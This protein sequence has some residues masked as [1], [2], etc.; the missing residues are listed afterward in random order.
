VSGA[1][2]GGIGNSGGPITQ[3]SPSD[4][5]I[6]PGL[7][8]SHTISKI[9]WNCFARAKRGQF[10]PSG[11]S[12][13]VAASRRFVY[14]SG[15]RSA[16]RTVYRLKHLG[17]ALYTSLYPVLYP[18]L[19]TDNKTTDGRSLPACRAIGPQT[20]TRGRLTRGRRLGIMGCAEWH[21]RAAPNGRTPL[22]DKQVGPTQGA[23]YERPYL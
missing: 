12:A 23:G 19:H 11:A 10:C 9:W 22:F 18:H 15:D 13:P 21:A 4:T 8:Y 17:G 3:L 7:V 5:T 1:Y 6:R 16:D 14:R 2:D 20:G